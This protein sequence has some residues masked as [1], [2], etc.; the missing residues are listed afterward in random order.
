MIGILIGKFVV[1]WTQDGQTHNTQGSFTH[2][3]LQFV[4][5]I[6]V[7]SVHASKSTKIPYR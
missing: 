1:F 3:V 7:T 5:K 4:T 6:K 2:Y